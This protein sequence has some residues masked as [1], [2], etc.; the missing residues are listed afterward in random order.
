[1]TLTST[2][3]SC[4]WCGCRWSRPSPPRS[5]P[6]P[7]GSP[8]CSRRG[9]RSSDGA[10]ARSPGWGECV[11]QE[12]PTYSS[13]YVAGAQAVL[14]DHLLPRRVRGAARAAAQRRDGRRGAGPGGRA[15]D[16]QGRAGDGAAGRP[17]ARR[18][19]LVRRLPRRDRRPGALGRVGRDPGQRPD[20]CSAWS[21]TTS[22]RATGGSSSRSSRAATS[23]RPGPSA[24]GSATSRSRSTPTPR[25]RWPTP[26]VLRRLDAFDLL[27]VEQPLAEDDLRQHALLARQL[28]D[29]GL[30]RRVGRLR[31]PRRR[32]PGPRAPRASSTSSPAG[33]AATSRRGAS[34]TSAG[35]RARPSGA[36]GCSRPGS[37]ARRTPRWP[38]CPA[39]P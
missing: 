29:A 19:H 26:R 8:C 11:A 37:A 4:T 33:S 24:S 10:A 30:P 17:A 3:W 32:R 1:M 2:R 34:T 36:A 20:R 39:S 13:E 7:S 23:S 5:A 6:R 31:R 21:R 16:G 35:P 12:E 15:P 14:V 28:R 18:G 38:G 25:T 27:L 9:P 22:T